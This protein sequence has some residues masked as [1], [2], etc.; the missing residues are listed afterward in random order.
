MFSSVWTVL[1]VLQQPPLHVTSV[2]L[3]NLPRIPRNCRYMP[4]YVASYIFFLSSHITLFKIL[5]YVRTSFL[6]V[7]VEQF[8]HSTIKY[9]LLNEFLPNFRNWYNFINK[10]SIFKCHFTLYSPICSLALHPSMIF[11][12]HKHLIQLAPNSLLEKLIS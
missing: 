1:F 3:R 10:Y 5:L 11:S 9:L 12:F 6:C 4:L 2:H 8:T 7:A